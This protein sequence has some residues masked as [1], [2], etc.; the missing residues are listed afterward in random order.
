[1]MMP[2]GL[3]ARHG[4]VA[5]AFAIGA[6]GAAAGWQMGDASNTARQITELQ[7]RIENQ[8]REHSEAQKWLELPPAHAT[9]D[10][11]TEVVGGYAGIVLQPRGQE[12]HTWRGALLGEPRLVYALAHAIQSRHRLP[13]RFEA[14]Q[15]GQTAELGFIVYGSP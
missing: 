3:S 8:R 7:G 5:G 4:L 1:M 15:A 14:I 12:G 9:W 6:A 2:K 13:V 10:R 11:L